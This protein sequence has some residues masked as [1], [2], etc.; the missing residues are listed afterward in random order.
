VRELKIMREDCDD[1]G[2][3]EH[4]KIKGDNEE[5]LEQ[6]E[7]GYEQRLGV[8]QCSATTCNVTA[9]NSQNSAEPAGKLI[10]AGQSFCLQ[11]DI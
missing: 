3:G 10:R 1:E 2:Q 6:R 5:R 9:S 7:R 4:V 8:E 11:G